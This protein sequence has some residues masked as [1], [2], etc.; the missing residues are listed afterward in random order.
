[1]HR[2]TDQL[3]NEH[4]IILAALAKAEGMADA[5][6]GG[7]EIPSESFQVFRDFLML[8]VHGV[9][10]RKEDEALFPWL[11]LKGMR[12]GAGC[13]GILTAEHV[14]VEVAFPEIKNNAASLASMRNYCSLLRNH[15]R[16]EE[17]IVFPFVLKSGTPEEAEPLLRAFAAIDASARRIGLEETLRAIDA[18]VYGI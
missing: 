16:R 2:I 1:M 9:H 18:I 8:Y 10:L 7:A 13:V 11:R 15:I 4:R 14:D 17:D 6:A 3:H 5:K 12:E